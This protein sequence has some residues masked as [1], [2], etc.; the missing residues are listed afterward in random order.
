[1]LNRSMAGLGDSFRQSR[2]D[3]EANKQRGIENSLRERALSLSE[4]SM[5]RA[6]AGQTEAWLTGDDN[7]LV[8]YR[9]TPDGLQQVIEGAAQKGK[10]LKLTQPPKTKASIGTFKMTTGLGDFDFHLDSPEDVQKVMELAQKMGGKSRAPGTME[11]SATRN[12]AKQQE[13]Q[14][15]ITSAETPEARAKAEAALQAFK[16]LVQSSRKNDDD[17]ETVTEVTPATKESVETIPG[18]KNYGAFG[19]DWLAKDEPDTEKVIPATPERRV[20]R[21]VPRGTAELPPSSATATTQP[22]SPKRP[23]RALAREY[24]KKYG[25]KATEQLKSEGFDVSGYAD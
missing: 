17:M 14:D 24:V 25:N 5:D 1:M 9:G 19:I 6:D 15:A 11:T 2:L 10:T 20:T 4:R 18:K 3:S 7:G 13:L 22:Q 16:E 8:H 23:T 21:K 12:F